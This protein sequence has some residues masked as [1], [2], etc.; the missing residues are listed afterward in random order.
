MTELQLEILLL[1][2]FGMFIIKAVQALTDEGG[3]LRFLVAPIEDRIDYL[4]NNLEEASNEVRLI[5]ILFFTKPIYRCPV[6]MSS[7]W[8][9][10]TWLWWVQ[11]SPLPI[12]SWPI[13]C[14]MLCGAMAILEHWL[15]SR[16]DVYINNEIGKDDN[17]YEKIGANIKLI[18]NVLLGNNFN[19]DLVNNGI[20][21]IK[22]IIE[23]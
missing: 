3:L 21:R 7:I 12:G 15:D 23:K 19:S 10:S 5:F 20:N 11:F 14:L 9:T 8:G 16:Q 4:L 1:L 22:E 13:Y 17:E 6:C 2:P 18:E